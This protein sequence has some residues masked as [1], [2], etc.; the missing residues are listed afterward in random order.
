MQLSTQGN[1]WVY[2]ATAHSLPDVTMIGS[3]VDGE[4]TA[5]PS[6]SAS[7]TEVG[8][9]VNAIDYHPI[10]DPNVFKLSN[11]N[12]TKT[13]GT[14]KVT[15]RPLYITGVDRYVDVTG[16]LQYTDEFTITN[17]VSGH[18][19]SGLT[20]RAEGTDIGHYTGAF[21][22]TLE[23][24]DAGDNDVLSNYEQHRTEGVLYIN[25]PDKEL[26]VV[27]ATSVTMYSGQP[28]T[29]QTYTVTFGYQPVSPLASNP[30]QYKLSTGD[31]VEITPTNTGATG[32]T[33]V[34]SFRNDFAISFIPSAHAANYNRITLDTGIVSVTTRDVRLISMSKTK[35]YDGTGVAWDSVQAGGSGF[36]EGEG[37]TYSNFRGGTTYSNVGTYPHA[38]TFVYELNDGTLAGNYTITQEYGDL[39]VTKATLTVK[40]N[41]IERVYGEP[42]EYTYTISGYQGSD[43]DD[44]VHGLDADHPSFICTGGQFSAIGY[45]TITPVVTG[46]SADNYDFAPATG[47]L[48]V[49]RRSLVINAPSVHIPV[50][51]RRH[52]VLRKLGYD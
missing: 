17:L 9:V 45:Y 52:V 38:N 25:S 29:D 23:V 7:I 41:D 39:A 27:S 50:G 28:I 32:I 24:K 47:T 15:A 3:F 8:E 16:E 49:K 13:E 12:I 4:V 40:A 6:A 30:R 48:T 11:Y 37:A 21:S 20:F 35:V 46:L 33:N 26:K 14:L 19:A 42:N 43:D 44:V 34:G 10:T 5:A 51:K 31:T 22:G 36:V 1:S 2:D 18:T